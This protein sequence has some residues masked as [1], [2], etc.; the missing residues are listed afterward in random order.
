VEAANEVTAAHGTHGARHGDGVQ[1]GR[2]EGAAAHGR[3]LERALFI[4]L[5]C[6]Q[7]P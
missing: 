7:F 2:I 3:A 5:V 4:F 6:A 1:G